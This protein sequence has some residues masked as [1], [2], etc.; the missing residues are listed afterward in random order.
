[1]S[2]LWIFDLSISLW[3]QPP[4]IRGTFRRVHRLLATNGYHNYDFPQQGHWVPLLGQVLE[5][6]HSH[7][8]LANREE[9][10]RALS[11]FETLWYKMAPW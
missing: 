3:H 8:F 4:A 10:D 11:L 7:G 6:F 1:M 2:L 5:L 9:V